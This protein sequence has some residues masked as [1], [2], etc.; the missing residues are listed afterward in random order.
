V[1]GYI[2]VRPLLRT[3]LIDPE[4]ATFLLPDAANAVVVD[5]KTNV[6]IITTERNTLN[7]LL[8]FMKTHP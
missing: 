6:S 2:L 5:T 1:G 8:D 3:T 4:E 7:H